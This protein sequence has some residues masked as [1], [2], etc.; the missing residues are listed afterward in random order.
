MFD[1]ANTLPVRARADV[2][3]EHVTIVPVVTGLTGTH[4][5]IH[6]NLVTV[7]TGGGTRG[8]H[9]AVDT[10]GTKGPYTPAC[11]I[12]IRFASAI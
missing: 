5:A 3:T 4:A 6:R 8:A 12:A 2:R 7:D 1:T 9:P 11:N 10:I